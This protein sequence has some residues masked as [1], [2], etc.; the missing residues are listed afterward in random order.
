MCKE[1]GSNL[2]KNW[3]RILLN[4]TLVALSLVCI[5]IVVAFG[6]NIA[7]RVASGSVES[8]AE[9]GK[10]TSLDAMFSLL[11]IAVT[12]W[13]GLNIYN[14]LS[15]E[16]VKEFMARTQE[17]ADKREEK[18][19]GSIQAA[20]DKAEIISRK[21]YTEVLISKLRLLPADRIE[22]YLATQL[23]ALERL[24][25]DILVQMILLEDKFNYAYSMYT[26]EEYSRVMEQGSGLS[27]EVQSVA[28]ACSEREPLDSKQ[29]AFLSG[30]I[31]LRKADFSF[32]Y[33]QCYPENTKEQW[34]R[35]VLALYGVAM[36]NFFGT[37]NLFAL[38][39]VRNYSP[40]EC[41]A[42]ALMANNI[43]SAYLVLIPRQLN[44]DEFEM[45][46]EAG[47]KAIKFATEV[48]PRVRAVFLRNLGVAYER[49]GNWSSAI[50]CYYEAYCLDSTNPKI[51]HCIASWHR[52]QIDKNL[53]TSTEEKEKCLKCATYWYWM[54]LI[55]GGGRI[56]G[57][58]WPRRLSEYAT[59]ID[60]TTPLNQELRETLQLGADCYNELQ[61][62]AKEK[63]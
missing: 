6:I 48:Q 7:I 40:E 16:E 19:K 46:I 55:H 44:S 50:Q 38:N 51:L 45:A 25:S 43:C 34:A 56:M 30:Y 1:K 62:I 63:R 36:D 33:A 23:A 24:P 15:R 9:I 42:I 5:A 49:S 3:S 57:D 2:S 58:A 37:K 21:V 14:V 59:E 39:D 8:A 13:I 54:E 20:E 53:I 41:Q 17:N 26:A 29:Q 35:T 61:A 52:K 60:A 28:E 4:V 22:N 11:G 18:L 27:D 10:S 12:V 32:F 47:E 31:A